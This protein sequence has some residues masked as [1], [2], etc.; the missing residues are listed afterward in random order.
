MK[1]QPANKILSVDPDSPAAEAGIRPGDELL[2]INGNEIN[3]EIDLTFYAA[4]ITD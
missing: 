3:D 2:S 4:D 1:D